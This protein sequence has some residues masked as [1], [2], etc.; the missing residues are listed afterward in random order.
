[1]INFRVQ[2]G[3]LAGGNGNGNGL[4]ILKQIL[5]VS[6]VNSL[7][8]KMFPTCG[9]ESC[10]ILRKNDVTWKEVIVFAAAKTTLYARIFFFCYSASSSHLSSRCFLASYGADSATSA[11]RAS[12][13]SS[14]LCPLAGAATGKF[15][16]SVCSRPSGLDLYFVNEKKKKKTSVDVTCPYTSMVKDYLENQQQLPSSTIFRQPLPRVPLLVPQHPIRHITF[17]EI[18]A[19]IN[20]MKDL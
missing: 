5:Y 6:S 11:R 13:W 9:R 19:D 12:A 10:R 14:T 17:C 7:T 2:M 4:I 18:L 15:V 8:E 16:V 1:M 20:K 3:C